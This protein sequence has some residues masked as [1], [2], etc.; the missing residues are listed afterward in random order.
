LKIAGTAAVK[1]LWQ[2]GDDDLEAMSMVRWVSRVSLVGL[3]V[4]TTARPLALLGQDTAGNGAIRLASRGAYTE[5][6]AR[7]GEGA[8]KSFCL[9]CHS[10]KEYAGQAFKVKWVSRTVFDLF[11]TIRTLMPDDNP[12]ML[13]A[14]DYVDIVAYILLLNNYPSGAAELPLDEHL[15]KSV[16]IDSLPGGVSASPPH[17]Y[18]STFQ[19]LTV[20]PAA[21]LQGAKSSRSK[22]AKR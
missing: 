17:G 10:A 2:Y 9:S 16:V 18:W 14:Q 5:D 22:G 4:L 1:A 21:Q 11:Q 13:P 7:R 12:G 15:L 20:V 8:Y 6:Q 3:L 19:A